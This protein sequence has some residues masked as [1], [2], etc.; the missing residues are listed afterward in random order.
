MHTCNL[1]TPHTKHTHTD[2]LPYT[3]THH[4]T[5]H[6]MRED[7]SFAMHHSF[8]P[9]FLLSIQLMIQHA[10]FFLNLPFILLVFV[11]ASSFFSSFLCSFPTVSYLSVLGHCP[12]M[13]MSR[14]DLD[15]II[16]TFFFVTSRRPL[17]TLLCIVAWRWLSVIVITIY[18][19]YSFVLLNTILH[20]RAQR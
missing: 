11:F 20:A 7:M 4:I 15:V 6:R 16:S 8:L 17:A 1:A 2:H 12:G 5:C 19:I 14:A 13:Y 9:S 18:M 10:E 3:N